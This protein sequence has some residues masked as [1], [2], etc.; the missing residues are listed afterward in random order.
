M[1]V[2]FDRGVLE[3]HTQPQLLWIVQLASFMTD[4]CEANDSFPLTNKTPTHLKPFT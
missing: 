3:K 4:T 2:P 1:V